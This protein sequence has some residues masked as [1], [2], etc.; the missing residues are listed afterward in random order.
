MIERA[1]FALTAEEVRHKLRNC[2]PSLRRPKPAK[3]SP[4]TAAAP[5]RHVA[6]DQGF[7]GWLVGSIAPGVSSPAY[8][9]QDGL[10][11]PEI[12]APSAWD[13]VMEQ[14]RKGYPPIMLWMRHEA[15]G[16][17]ACTSRGTLRLER[18]HILGGM[19]EAQI[20]SG[21]L[22]RM[23]LSEIGRG[24]IGC[25]I[26]YS[27]G[28]FAY[29]QRDGQRVRVVQT[30]V[31]DHVALVRNGGGERAL[32][33]AARVFAVKADQRDQLPRAWSDARTESWKAMRVARG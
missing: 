8:S 20:E 9:P 2:P 5:R 14:Q 29:E 25:S 1:C 4:G 6:R 10:T 27:H 30:C 26:A 16:M 22:E 13:A 23:L 19:F 33:A 17:L 11:L 15:G 12:F 21:P 7:S 18:H 28:R 31:V 24:G 3:R 32:F